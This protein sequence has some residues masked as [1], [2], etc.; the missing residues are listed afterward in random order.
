M[1]LTDEQ[2]EKRARKLSDE[3]YLNEIIDCDGDYYLATIDR[4]KDA[5]ESLLLLKMCRETQIISARL[6]AHI[7]YLEA[8]LGITD[9]NN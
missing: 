6:D 9:T 4:L 1:E 3:A 7:D 5:R 2:L 8:L